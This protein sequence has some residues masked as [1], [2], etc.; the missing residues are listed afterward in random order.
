MAGLWK[1]PWVRR[2]RLRFRRPL[3]ILASPVFARN[4]TFVIK[5][6]TVVADPP[7]FVDWHVISTPQS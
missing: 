2:Q 5:T 7:D 4:I 3:Q 6:S 1:I